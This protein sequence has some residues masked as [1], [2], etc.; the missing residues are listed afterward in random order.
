MT[1]VMS[2]YTCVFH[3]QHILLLACCCIFR[4]YVEVTDSAATSVPVA[5][6]VLLSLAPEVSPKLED[7][8]VLGCAPGYVVYFSRSTSGVFFQETGGTL[9]EQ[10]QQHAAA[11]RLRRHIQRLEA[12]PVTSPLPNKAAAL[13]V[14]LYSTLI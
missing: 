1:H 10:A 12:F 3:L 6:L 8:S 14:F 2:T 9:S 11:A 4:F 13:T 7:H 5:L